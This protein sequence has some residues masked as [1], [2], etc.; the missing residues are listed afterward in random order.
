VYGVQRE[1]ALAYAI[2]LYGLALLPKIIA[3]VVIVAIGPKGFSLRSAL[4][5]PESQDA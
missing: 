5:R 3:G 2:V 1:V 4:S